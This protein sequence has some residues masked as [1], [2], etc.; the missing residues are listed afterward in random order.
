MEIPGNPVLCCFREPVVIGRPIWDMYWCAAGPS[1]YP[2]R[3]ELF[4]NR[5]KALEEQLRELEKN[6]AMIQFKC[7][8]YDQAIA[9]GNEEHLKE[10]I[11]D[12]LPS[13]IKK[14]YELAHS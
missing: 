8:Y 11:P 4:E 3:R 1:T 6:M 9:D 13:D 7:W 12:N 5:K 2:N 14:L 10:M